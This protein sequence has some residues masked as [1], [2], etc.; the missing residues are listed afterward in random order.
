MK[1]VDRRTELAFVKGEPVTAEPEES[2]SPRAKS[3]RKEKRERA[4][5][6]KPKPEPEDQGEGGEPP[7][8]APVAP[9]A[10]TDR[11]PLTTRIRSKFGIA[12]KR[13]SLERQLSGETPNTVQDIL[14]EALEPW[15]RDRGFLRD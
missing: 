2:K 3:E 12:L 4:K 8:A 14:E 15:L 5:A 1:K 6:V 11:M 9:P 10:Y 7:A 13:A